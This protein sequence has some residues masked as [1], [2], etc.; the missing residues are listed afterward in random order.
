VRRRCR[1]EEQWR[2]TGGIRTWNHDGHVCTQVYQYHS[3]IS[4]VDDQCFPRVS[5]YVMVITM[6]HEL[7][8]HQAASPHLVGV[9][10]D[11]ERSFQQAQQ[12]ALVH[13]EA[14]RD[15]LGTLCKAGVAGGGCTI[16][17]LALVI[18]AACSC[19]VGG[20]PCC[21]CICSRQAKPSPCQHETA[22]QELCDAGIIYPLSTNDDRMPGRQVTS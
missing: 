13:V 12:L 15:V 8:H 17:C 3:D 19:A 18:C 16:A 10:A 5:C 1:R 4:Q 22:A 14:D 7:S 21:C 6:H 11:I 9:L 20:R 2:A